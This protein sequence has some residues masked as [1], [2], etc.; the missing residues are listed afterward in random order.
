M[1]LL[2]ITNS[3][4]FLLISIPVRRAQNCVGLISG[5]IWMPQLTRRSIVAFEPNPDWR[6][7]YA[8][9]PE[10]LKYIKKTAQKYDLGRDIKFNH[11]LI[12]AEFD[13]RQGHWRLKVQNAQGEAFNDLCDVL[14]AANGH[15][16]RWNW[17]NINGLATFEGLLVH[18]AQWNH[19][20]DYTGK[21]V[22]VLGNGSSAIQIVPEMAKQASQLINFIR[23][24]TWIIPG[25]GSS[26]IDGKT[27]Y[28]YSEQEKAEFRN[29]PEALKAYRKQ[30]QQG[31]N[32]LFSVV[33][34]S[35]TFLELI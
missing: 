4:T 16:S 19:E 5:F 25:L 2:L 33:S 21:R 10:I 29:N 12:G 3:V 18:S 13:E 8:K 32:E 15:L 26:I 20:F 24:P 34:S 30:I 23:G 9:G 28:I 11:K 27:N 31:S 35:F 7:Y 6:S 14:V 1:I 17:P 22:A